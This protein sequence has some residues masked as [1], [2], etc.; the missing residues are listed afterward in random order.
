MPGAAVPGVRLTPRKPPGGLP[1]PALQLS[2]DI[3]SPGGLGDSVSAMDLGS[4]PATTARMAGNAFQ[5]QQCQQ[6]QQQQYQQQF[7][8]PQPQQP[9]LRPALVP[10]AGAG[11]KGEPPAP[12]T[13]LRPSEAP[14]PAGGA[15]Q[16][17][18]PL[19]SAPD[20]APGG[21]GFLPPGS[22]PLLQQ[23]QQQQ[24]LQ[25]PAG[26]PQLRPVPAD[27]WHLATRRHQG[28]PASLAPTLRPAR[29]P[30]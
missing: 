16:G 3:G 30:N 29:P 4:P 28:P 21:P 1:T 2:P 9:L 19:W 26:V 14:A 20:A 23:Q 24:R 17:G 7:Q 15:S 22:Q 5:R 8:R 10:A 6:Y 18:W 25:G 13:A 27:T 11:P 12:L